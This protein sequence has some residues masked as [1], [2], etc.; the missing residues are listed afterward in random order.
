MLS[1]AFLDGVPPAE[2]AQW[3]TGDLERELASVLEAAREAWPDVAV[4]DVTFMRFVGERAAGAPRSWLLDLPAGDL[5]LAC[6]CARGDATAL[7]HIEREYVPAIDGIVRGRLDPTLAA[8]AMQRVRELLFVG[9]RPR[10][11]D[12]SGR[13]ELGKWLTITAVRTGL[14]VLREGARETALDDSE[15]G[16]LVDTSADPELEHLRQRYQAEF[17]QAF[18]DAFAQLEA[19]ER[20]LL[21]HNVLDGHGVDRIAQLYAIHRSTASRWLTAA[22]AELI[23]RTKA[24]LRT[25]LHISPSEL[26]SLLRALADQI[27]VTLEGILR[28]TRG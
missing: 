12:Y 13:G 3:Q 5:W 23:K 26:D 21:R 17:K 27:D 22:R 1:N 8:E 18:A 19:R 25:R 10:I 20:N 9:E 24:E 14:R 15:L 4:P 16:A 6:A 7:G 11:L 28:A 2:R